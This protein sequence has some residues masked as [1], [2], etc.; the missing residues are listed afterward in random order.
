[1]TGSQH[2]CFKYYRLMRTTQCFF[3]TKNFLLL[4]LIINRQNGLQGS[5]ANLSNCNR[6]VGS[7]RLECQCW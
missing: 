4:A 1:M 3:A 2:K 6:G 7:G 5:F